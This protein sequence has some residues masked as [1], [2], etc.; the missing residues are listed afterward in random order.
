MPPKK[1]SKSA[2]K[3]VDNVRPRR[4]RSRT[5]KGRLFDL[6]QKSVNVDSSQASDAESDPGVSQEIQCGQRTPPPDS[7]TSSDDDSDSAGDNEDSTPVKEDKWDKV[8][9]AL[10]QTAKTVRA[11][12]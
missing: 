6:S 4:K 11:V 7:R 1:R 2:A 10:A 3:L 12:F 9:E 5:E 8:A